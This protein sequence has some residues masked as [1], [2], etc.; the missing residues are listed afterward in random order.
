MRSQNQKMKEYCSILLNGDLEV[1]I[2]SGM[3]IDQ[4]LSN[5]RPPKTQS[6]SS[7]SPRKIVQMEQ[8]SDS[9]LIG[10]N[11]NEEFGSKLGNGP[12][13]DL[14]TSATR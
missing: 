7:V 14:V 5:L 1:V 2:S 11:V 9:G 13:C 12:I 6:S 10:W 8:L 3:K 4:N